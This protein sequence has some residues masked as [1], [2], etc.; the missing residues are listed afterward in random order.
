[1][2]G[3]GLDRLA[4]AL[5]P[6]ACLHAV[7]GWVRD[8][9]LGTAEG[10]G[11]L[12]LATGL[13]PEVVMARARAA[14]LKAIPTGLAHGTVTVILEGQ[15][16]EITTFRGEGAYLDGRR[17]STVTLGVDLAQD[18]ARRD[19]TVNALALPV[20]AMGDPAWRGRVID[21]FG[22]IADLDRRLIRAVGDPLQRFAEDGLRP[23]R[24]CRFASQLGFAVD[25]A[26]LAAIGQR[27]DTC[28]KVSV[29][30]V[31][32]ELTKLLRGPE[33]A[34]GLRLLESTG[35]LDLW[36]PELRPMVGCPQNRH[37][38]FDVWEH[39]LKAME[40]ADPD[41][42]PAFAWALLL[43]D[44]GKPASRTQDERGEIHFYGHEALSVDLADKLLGRLKA[45]NQLK[46]RV[47][48]YIQLHGLHADPEG[49]DATYRRLLKRITEAGL[50]P[51]IWELFCLADRWGKGWFETGHPDGRSGQEWWNDTRAQ[52]NQACERLNAVRFP[53][54]TAK[55]LALDGHAL[56][57]LA[58]R[59]PGPWLGE[60]QKWLLEQVLEEPARNTHEALAELGRAW[61]ADQR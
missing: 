5:G 26:T 35:L 2:Q 24:A 37:H 21:P 14:G 4:E 61:L 38:R 19:F 39:I 55:E 32:T 10:S 9:W 43:H 45:P 46:A 12:D 17:P 25:A 3:I 41:H 57:D 49:S 31:F 8:R 59:S 42:E 53:G 15:P 22:G 60:L 33:P 40:H 29:E 1:L 50:T 7:G 6:G 23:L 30:R 16:L 48:S 28:A 18:L 36:L 51:E 11:D 56:M 34:R 54:M 27:L 47:A 13:L 20:E 58:G 44:A 52:W